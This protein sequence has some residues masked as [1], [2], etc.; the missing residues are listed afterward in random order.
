LCQP[1]W[2]ELLAERVTALASV[3]AFTFYFRHSY[4]Q[5]FSLFSS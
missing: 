5:A 4:F 1:L 3:R 2:F